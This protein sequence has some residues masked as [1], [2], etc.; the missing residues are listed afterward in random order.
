MFALR[1]AKRKPSIDTKASHWSVGEV[2][3]AIA[4]ALH[5]GGER[6]GVTESHRAKAKL[7]GTGSILTH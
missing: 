3:R 5:N 1:S 7:L 4:I 2:V 6:I